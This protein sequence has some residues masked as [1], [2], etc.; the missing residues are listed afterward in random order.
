MVHHRRR[1]RWLLLLVDLIWLEGQRYEFQRK[2]IFGDDDV[3]TC[4]AGHS[5]DRKR[6]YIWSKQTQLN[7]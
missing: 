5:A 6:T 7:D 3:G 1:R 4:H 2:C